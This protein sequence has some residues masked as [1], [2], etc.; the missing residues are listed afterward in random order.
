MLL[1]GQGTLLIQSRALSTT[2]CTEQ[3]GLPNMGTV[4]VYP[5]SHQRV[6]STCAARIVLMARI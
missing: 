3:P 1:P 5:S 6:L 4:L 2:P